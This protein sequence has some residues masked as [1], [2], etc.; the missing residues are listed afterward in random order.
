MR[1]KLNKGDYSKRDD[2]FTKEN[3]EELMTSTCIG[4]NKKL[5]KCNSFDTMLNGSTG[6][7]VLFHN[8]NIVSANIGDSRAVLLFQGKKSFKST[9]NLLTLKPKAISVDQVPEIEGERERI[10]MSGGEIRPS[11]RN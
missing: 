7:I 8:G 6:I 4:L 5:N 1:L 10:L 9:P 11:Y 2:D 3:Y